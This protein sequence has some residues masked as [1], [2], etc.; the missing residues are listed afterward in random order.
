MVA[1]Q[2][3]YP[4]VIRLR[5]VVVRYCTFGICIALTFLKVIFYNISDQYL[6]V[7]PWMHPTN[8]GHYMSCLVL[9]VKGIVIFAWWALADGLMAVVRTALSDGTSIPFL[10]SARCEVINM[11]FVIVV[12]P[13]P[14]TSR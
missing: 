10:L 1:L 12:I 7:I 9:S 5:T 14:L 8:T 2:H 6:V 4:I 3:H 11:S 13:F